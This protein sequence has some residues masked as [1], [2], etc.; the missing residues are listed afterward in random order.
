MPVSVQPEGRDFRF[1]A[2]AI[3]I[4]TT[5]NTLGC[6]PRSPRGT[7]LGLRPV[8]E[9]VYFCLMGFGF[10]KQNLWGNL[11]PKDGKEE[12]VVPHSLIPQDLP[13]Q[14][15]GVRRGLWAS[16]QDRDPIFLWCCW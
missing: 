12:D 3:R 15:L 14:G 4:N 10:Q 6:V 2:F 5:L 16:L 11:G 7:P 13:G 9:G 8:S 1:P